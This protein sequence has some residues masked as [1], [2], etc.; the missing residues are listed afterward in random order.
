MAYVLANGIRVHVQRLNGQRGE[1]AD[2]F[3]VVPSPPPVVFIHGLAVDNLSSYYYSLANPVARVGAE[4]ILYDLRGH[5]LS[6]RPPDGYTVA[7]AV[8]DLVG[9]LDALGVDRPA[10]LVGNSYGGVVALRAA[11]DVPERVRSLVLIEAHCA[12]DETE[13]SDWAELM[14][15]T[16]TATALSLEHDR[17]PDQL[18]AVGDRKLAR[19]ARTAEALLS[20]T[21]L[22]EDLAAMETFTERDLAGVHCPVLAVYGQHSDLAPSAR[23]LARHVP[24]CRLEI[25]PG[26]AHTVLRE[27]TGTVLALVLDWLAA[28]STPY[29]AAG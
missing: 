13:G 12:D 9:V 23:A 16:L 18:L 14:A 21:T 8:A 10:H 26:L 1:G 20:S 24:V 4:A 15:D 17:L 27:A 5:G 3:P 11:L 22:V 19:M 25:I 6:E 2:A 28:P 29:G 7:D